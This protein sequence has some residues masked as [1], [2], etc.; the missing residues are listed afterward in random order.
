MIFRIFVCFCLYFALFFA[1]YAAQAKT[2]QNVKL[3][4]GIILAAFGTSVPEAKDSFVHIERI[5]KQNFPNVPIRWTY[6]SQIIRT[7]LAKQ[8]EHIL[9]IKDS[10]NALHQDGVQ[11][12]RIQPLHVMAGEEYSEL[13]RAVLLAIKE[14]PNRFKHVFLGRP[15]LES[16]EDAKV[17]GQALITANAAKRKDNVALVLMG[18]GQAH[19]RAALVFEGTRSVFN[20]LDRNI[21][22]ATVEGQRDFKDLLA[23]LQAHQVKKV[24]LQP[25]MVV[26]GDHARNDLAG[27]EDDSWAELLKA[28]GFEVQVN[29]AG[30]GSL[31]EVGNLYVK[32]ALE[33]SDDL[34]T[35]PRKK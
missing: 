6:T 25:L 3:K 15:L 1:P 8:G 18:H 28:A 14:Q 16:V 5:F 10:L 11:V 32:H 12:V 34:T 17:V 35:E 26:A 31:D 19:G 27:S 24:M 2:N 20:G 9:G 21:Y 29:L 33:S 4:E 13:E 30:L 23:D 22:M 7:K